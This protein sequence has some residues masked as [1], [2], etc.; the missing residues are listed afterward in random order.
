MTNVNKPGKICVIFEAGERYKNT[1]INKN[2]QKRPDLLNNLVGILIR[3]RK[4]RNCVMADIEKMHR[5]VLIREQDRE[6]L[7]FVW[8]A[9]RKSSSETFL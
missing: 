1:S 5:Q 2:L 6:P 9:K 4:E 8:R 3:F 7:Q